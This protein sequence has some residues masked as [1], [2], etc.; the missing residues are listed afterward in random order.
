MFINNVLIIVL[1]C[2]SFSCGDKDNSPDTTPQGSM[3]SDVYIEQTLMLYESKTVTILGKGFQSGDILVFDSGANK[4][5]IPLSDI[6]ETSVSFTVPKELVDGKYIIWIKRGDRAETLGTT[7]IKA[8]LLFNVPDKAGATVKGVVFC[9]AAPV[10]GVRV[11]DGIRTTVTDDNG[12]YWLDSDKSTKNVFYTIPSGYEPAGTNNV[13]PGFWAAF[14]IDKDVCEQHDFELVRVDNDRHIVLAAADFHLAGRSSTKD[15]QQFNDGFMVDVNKFVSE[16]KGTCIYTLVLGDITWDRFWYSHDY[17]LFSYKNTV[18]SYPTPMF[19]VMGNHDNDCY[20]PEDFGAEAA[21]RNALG[22]TY[23]SMNLGKVHYVMLDNTVFINEGGKQGTMGDRNYQKHLTANQL[24]WLKEDL[25]AVS[26]N[27]PV[28]VGFHC[29]TH[30]NDNS[31]FTN[32]NSFSPASKR[33]EFMQCFSGFSNVHFLSGHTHL[34]TTMILNNNIIEHNTAAVSETWWWSGALSPQSICTDGTPSGYGVYQMNGT[35]INWYYK[36]I[37][38]SK[39]KQ[40]RAYDM[41]VIKSFFSHT[42]VMD[43]LKKYG[44]RKDQ[45]ND[46][47]SVESNMVYLNIWNYDLK[48]KISVKENGKELSVK[49]IYQRDPLHTITFDL[50]RVEQG[51]APDDGWATCLNTHMFEVKTEKA[52]SSL[53][54]VVTDRFGNEYKETMIR[55]KAFTTTME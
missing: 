29:Q 12:F 5:N 46:Y 7:T 47:I 25:A 22:P 4:Y 52:D 13:T 53:E 45:P 18:L 38:K 42:D 43:K 11:S 44:F 20:I 24:N 3:I 17:D 55:P 35:D 15:L 23:Y 28:V 51:E 36:G 1:T 16:N 34:N 41:N 48:W 14:R 6:K 40:F 9:G 49:R 50:P 37:G 2:L 26:K 10:K 54:I 21:Y 8:S 31:T 32:N 33:D 27:T 39:D 30:R 19:H